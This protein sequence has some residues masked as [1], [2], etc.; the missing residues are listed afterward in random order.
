M[1]K[2]KAEL[3]IILTISIGLSV[4]LPNFL[5][6]QLT[7]VMPSAFDFTKWTIGIF[8]L[9]YVVYF[10]SK[11][12]DRKVSLNLSNGF[13]ELYNENNQ[14]TKKGHFEGGRLYNGSV[15]IYKQDGTISH[16]E[17]IKDG[18]LIENRSSGK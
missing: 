14:I 2:N 13:H 5:K 10:S 15:N 11:P 4:L 9:L 16:I 18:V 12:K 7:I 3:L 8:V 1:K 6:K 17:I